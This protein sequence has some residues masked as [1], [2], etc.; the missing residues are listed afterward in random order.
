MTETLTSNA[1]VAALSRLRSSFQARYARNLSEL[2]NML[3][4]LVGTRQPNPDVSSSDFK[5]RASCSEA[6]MPCDPVHTEHH[7]CYRLI[8]QIASVSTTRLLSSDTHDNQ[9]QA[10]ASRCVGVALLGLNISILSRRWRKLSN[11]QSCGPASF[12]AFALAIL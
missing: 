11:Q 10:F 2:A 5:N 7:F 8:R 4:A 1:G 9:W 12:E 3:T 6:A